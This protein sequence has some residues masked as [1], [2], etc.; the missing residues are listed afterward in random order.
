LGSAASEPPPSGL[1]PP[2]TLPCPPPTIDES[3]DASTPPSGLRTGAMFEQ[4][5]VAQSLPSTHERPIAHG[6][7]GP[8]Q[9][10]STSPSF[11]TLSMHDAC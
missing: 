6:A 11:F 5:P 4:T 8:P 2:C 7:Q 9:S 10:T 1:A 3:M